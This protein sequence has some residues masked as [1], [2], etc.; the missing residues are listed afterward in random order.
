MTTS[1]FGTDI[2]KSED[3]KKRSIRISNGTNLPSDPI[4]GYLAVNPR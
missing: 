3:E 2:D 1:Q 4:N